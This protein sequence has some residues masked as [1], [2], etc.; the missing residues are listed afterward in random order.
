MSLDMDKMFAKVLQ[1]KENEERRKMQRANKIDK[2][3]KQD[4]ES[5]G[6]KSEDDDKEKEM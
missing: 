6:E 5:E 3:I 4:D 1:Q 2:Y